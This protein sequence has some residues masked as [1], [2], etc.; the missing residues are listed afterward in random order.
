MNIH[1]NMLHGSSV[2]KVH[3]SAWAINRVVRGCMHNKNPVRGELEQYVSR[4]TEKIFLSY[5][6]YPH[7]LCV[8]KVV[9]SS[10]I[11]NR[12][13]RSKDGPGSKVERIFRSSRYR[14]VLSVPL[15]QRY[16][17]QDANLESIGCVKNYRRNVH[18]VLP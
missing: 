10:L 18:D 8:C 11:L 13:I 9:F 17:T 16:K 7:V 6:T 3:E 14:K 2:N 5:L 4:W 1:V 12:S 15:I